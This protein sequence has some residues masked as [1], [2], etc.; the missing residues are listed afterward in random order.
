MMNDEL[1]AEIVSLNNRLDR[2][3]MATPTGELRELLTDAR[4]MLSYLDPREEGNALTETEKA[5]L[6]G[7]VDGY[8]DDTGLST[9]FIINLKAKLS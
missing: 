3:I 7:L 5:S 9:E 6:L 2:A 1:I 8:V 4:M